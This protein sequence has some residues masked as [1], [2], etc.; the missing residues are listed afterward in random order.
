MPTPESARQRI[1]PLLL[2]LATLPLLGVVAPA[3]GQPPP[4]SGGGGSGGGPP[5]G[6]QWSLG[7]G[8]IASPE[9]YAGLDDVDLQ[10]V[11]LLTYRH[12]RFRFQG[13]EAG[14]TLLGG[15]AWRLDAVARGRF[16]GYD[17]EDSPFLRGMRD[18]RFTA[19]A[20]LEATYQPAA[21]GL[22]LSLVHDVLDRHGGWAAGASLFHEWGVRRWRITPRLG[23][24]WGSDDLLDYYFGVRPGEAAPGRPAYAP[25]AAVTWEAGVSV[26]YLSPA[27]WTLFALA[28]LER[29]PGEVDAS[30]IVVDD[31]A[32]S[33]FVG[34]GYRF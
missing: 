5:S 22:E 10:P 7:L 17:A 28:Q 27:R 8:V 1:R 32:V 6:P 25:G 24:E 12:G 34:V 15:E 3:G 26:L 18:R 16:G 30:P 13:I 11:P 9:P 4:G 21:T 14:Y 31:T 20:G 29:L 2:L 19:D 33:G 23:A